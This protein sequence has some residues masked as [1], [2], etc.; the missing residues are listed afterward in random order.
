MRGDL[1]YQI[2]LL[3][4]IRP[5][6][7]L[8]LAHRLPT[9]S[10]RRLT[11]LAGVALGGWLATPAN[12]W[13]RLRH[14][15]CVAA[16]EI[17]QPPVFIIGHWRSG[18]THLH[19][20]MGQDEQFG[21]LRMFQA[22]APDCSLTTRRWLPRLLQRVV[23]AK[24]PMDNMVWPM[25]APQ[26]EE[27]ALA[28]VTPYSWYLSFLFP[29]QAVRSFERFVLLEGASA[30]VRREVKQRLLTL[31]KIT[32]LHENGR[33]LLLKNPVNT[34]RIPLLLELFPEAKFVFIHRSPYEV[35][36]STMNLHRQIMGLTSLQDVSDELIET[37]VIELH[38]RVIETYLR[39]RSEV[40]AGNL[41]EVAYADLDASPVETVGGIYRALS[42][43]GF[44][45]A[46]PR[47]RAY[48]ASQAAYR[49]NDFALSA[50]SAE[51]VEEA[52][53]RDFEEW[54]YPGR[55]RAD[56]GAEPAEL[57]A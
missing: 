26:E 20:L 9:V 48:V 24:R 28:K 40:P 1:G 18:T 51:L 16:T 39:D 5:T 19:N 49:K 17:A 52:W 45:R 27:I 38:Q 12:L 55:T 46:E 42:L 53:R 10:P 33:R 47:V 44:E 50:R 6:T 3:S 56:A 25:D 13:Q 32:S 7:M 57:L 34:C 30:R 43:D 15:R 2:G 23:P 22:L 29:K 54:G 37:N 14:G 41:V 11:R 21:S 36:P 8:R 31:L 4:A 35:Y